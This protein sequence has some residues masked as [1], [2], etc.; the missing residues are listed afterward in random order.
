MQRRSQ[1]AGCAS[2]L[3]LG[4]IDDPGLSIFLQASVAQFESDAGLLVAREGN[5][6]LQVEVPVDPDRARIDLRGHGE[7]PLEMFR[8]DAAAERELRIV[9]A[10]DGFFDL[11]IAQHRQ[12]WAELLL[13]DQSRIVADV[14]NNRRFD[15][16]ALALQNIA[17]RN[18]NAVLFGIVQEALHPLEMRLILQRPY[19]GSR[20]GAV[21]DD[22]LAG[23]PPEFLAEFVILRIMNIEALDHDAAL[24]GIEGGAGEQLGRYFL[25]IDIVEHNGGVV[26]AQLPRA[27]L[28]P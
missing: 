12:N 16:I 7:G 15:E 20:L 10:R 17:A 5:I 25:W 28:Q 6:G 3:L 1:T 9:R 14:A 23:Q 27:D 22:S 24:A 26:A 8:P 11:G 13:P 2:G 18:D 21:I 4:H 19:L